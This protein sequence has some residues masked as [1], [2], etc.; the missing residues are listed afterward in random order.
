MRKSLDSVVLL[1]SLQAIFL[2][3]PTEV[4]KPTLDMADRSHV[5]LSPG[6]S[7]CREVAFRPD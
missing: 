3:G 6:L 2:I 1:A 5:T 4:G 7:K